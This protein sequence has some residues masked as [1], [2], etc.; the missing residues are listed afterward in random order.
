MGGDSK[1]TGG[2][3][4]MGSVRE[5]S[6]GM[7]GSGVTGS[8]RG[9]AK[10]TGGSRFMGSV[11]E[12]SNGTVCSGITGSRRGESKAMS[13]SRS[14]GS[15]RENSNGTVAL[16]LAGSRRGD[17]TATGGSRS[18]GSIREDSK[19]AAG[20]GEAGPGG[21]GLARTRNRGARAVAAG[22]AGKPAS[23]QGFTAEAQRAQRSRGSSVQGQVAR[24]KDFG[25]SRGLTSRRR[26]KC[27]NSC[28]AMQAARG[29]RL[30]LRRGLPAF[31]GRARGRVRR[32]SG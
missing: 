8:R 20:L 14:M 3:W 13:G 22:S 16:G 5:D 23:K 2:A 26:A 4:F 31:S 32:S 15:I 12:D 1:A 25:A 10:A 18:M 24:S 9:D 27:M 17:A 7:V 6:R 11:R 29:P 30:G 28:A 19:G 21:A